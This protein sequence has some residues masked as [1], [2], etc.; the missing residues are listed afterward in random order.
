[1]NLLEVKNLTKTY[2]VKRPFRASL[3][4]QALRG[5]SLFVRP[6]ETLAVVGESG[7]GKSTLAKVLMK[8]EEKSG[9]E[10]WI[11]EREIGSI[12]SKE[13][14]AHLQMIFQDPYSSL[15]PRKKIFDIVAEPLIIAGLGSEKIK[16][17]VQEVAS[18]VG[19]RPEILGRYP[20]MLSGGQR[21]RVGIARA[22]VTRPKLIVCDE[23]VSALDVSVQAQVLNLLLDLQSQQNLS[24]LF[25]S[26]DLGVVRFLA[27]RV[28]VMY[29]GQIVELANRDELFNRPLHPY[30]QLLLSSNP[31]LQKQKEGEIFKDSDLPSP[32]NPP[33]GCSFHTRCPF[34]NEECRQKTPILRKIEA[35]GTGEVACHHAESIYRKKAGN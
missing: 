5:V 34:A 26:H 20:H 24:F 27:H 32:L 23:P 25:I 33:S 19:L 31:H 8:I 2:Q 4:L 15:N 9:G 6:G 18:L 12:T 3:N 22:L 28:A 16:A 13:L 10:A 7:C 14:P 29:L 30:T 35:L 11:D 1:M 21:Q 17:S